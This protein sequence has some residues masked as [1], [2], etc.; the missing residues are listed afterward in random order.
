MS[1]YNFEEDGIEI[2]K[3]LLPVKIIELVKSDIDLESAKLKNTESETWRKDSAL[4][5]LSFGTT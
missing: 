5:R 2:R 4:Y 3:A 1:E